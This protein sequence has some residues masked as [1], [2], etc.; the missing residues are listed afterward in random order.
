M[1][2]LC[3]SG[4]NRRKAGGL[5]ILLCVRDHLHLTFSNLS[6]LPMLLP[7][8]ELPPLE[9]LQLLKFCPY[10]KIQLFCYLFQEGFS[11][12][13]NQ[14]SFLYLLKPEIVLYECRLTHSAELPMNRPFP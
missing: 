4:L 12:H 8:L 7:L 2:I 10:V 13:P 6:P 3:S 5:C 1:T 11:D 9:N 14:K